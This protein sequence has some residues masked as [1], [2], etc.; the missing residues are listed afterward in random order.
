MEQTPSVKRIYTSIIVAFAWLLFI[1]FWL[2][3]Y[4]TNLNIIQNIGVF[5]AS[6]VVVGILEVVIWVPWALKQ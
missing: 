5:L 4:A 2:I 1:S 6:V 3:F